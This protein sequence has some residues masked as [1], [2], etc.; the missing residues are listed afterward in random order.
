MSSLQCAV[1]RIAPF[2]PGVVT[3]GTRSG[4][5]P[6]DRRPPAKQAAYPRA[7]RWARRSEVVRFKGVGAIQR[8]AFRPDDEDRPPFRRG[9]PRNPEV[10]RANPLANGG[11]DYR[12]AFGDASPLDTHQFEPEAPVRLFVNLLEPDGV[13]EADATRVG[14]RHEP[15]IANQEDAL[16]VHRVRLDALQLVHEKWRKRVAEI[17]GERG[18]AHRGTIVK[19]HVVRLIRRA[20]LSIALE[21][22]DRIDERRI[23]PRFHRSPIARRGDHIRRGLFDDA[24]AVELELTDD[25]GLPR[26]WR[27]GADEPSHRLPSCS[28]SASRDTD[29]RGSRPRPS[30]PRRRAPPPRRECDGRRSS[31]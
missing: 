29:R 7:T 18:G 3:I 21:M 26:A 30:T 8:A 25:R 9:P 20:N 10:K 2:Q 23:P 13:L 22:G 11:L 6:R 24:E 4:A 16:F 14:G 1:S 5:P 31:A 19:L 12:D 17:D 27:A 28:T 15:E